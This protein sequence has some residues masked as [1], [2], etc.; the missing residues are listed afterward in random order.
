M[1]YKLLIFDWDGTLMDSIDKI[2]LCMQQAALQEGILEPSKAAVKNI[3]GLSL[4][5]AVEVL[6]P[7]LEQNKYHELVKAYQHQYHL[8]QH[9]DTP[10]YTGIKRLL[11]R[12][13]AAG[14]ILAVATGKGRNGL[15]QMIKK[16]NSEHLFTATICADEALSK[17][18]PLMLNSLL[19]KLHIQADDAL[20]IGDSIYD[21]KMANNANVDCLGVSYGVHEQSILCE[22]NPVAIVDNLAT[23]LELYI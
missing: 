14:Y 16:T 4:L 10:F 7:G 17:P 19:D 13:K 20:M 3:I 2:V 1:K 23:Q 9:V 15:N 22:A 5:N 11:Q 12:L 8:H 21:L 6:F 18:D